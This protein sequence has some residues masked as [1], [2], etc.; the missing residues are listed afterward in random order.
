MPP[1][2]PALRRS[3]PGQAV[4]LERLR[5]GA[6]AAARARSCVVPT[7][8]NGEVCLDLILYA[9]PLISRLHSAAYPLE[10]AG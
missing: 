10:A 2:A 5:A 8:D 9:K 7:P 4:F 3:L 6:A 1:D